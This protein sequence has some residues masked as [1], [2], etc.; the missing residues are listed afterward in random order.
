MPLFFLD[1]T[2]CVLEIVF[3]SIFG[4]YHHHRG[5]HFHNC[6]SKET[7]KLR[8]YL[9]M[10]EEKRLMGGGGRLLRVILMKVKVIEVMKAEGR[11]TSKGPVPNC[12]TT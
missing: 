9:G 4:G 10:N 7:N 5:P 2:N 8:R 11:T 1:L 6:V 12:P 3:F